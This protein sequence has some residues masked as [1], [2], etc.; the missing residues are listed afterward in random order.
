L[1]Y[2]PTCFGFPLIGPFVAAGLYDISRRRSKGL[3]ITWSDVL[4]VVIGQGR[5]ELGWMAFVVLFVFWIWMYQ[6]RLLFALFVGYRGFSTL[7]TFV[8]FLMTSQGL[9]FLFV[10][11][12]VG[13]VLATVLFSLTVIAMPMLLDHDVDFVTAISTSVRTVIENPRAM[14]TFGIAVAVLTFVAMVPMFLGLLVVLPILG[15]ATWHLY[16]RAHIGRVS[17]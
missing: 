10:G 7:D 15:H 1:A 9:T 14:F 2:P 8:S 4:S 6:I 11:T 5:R 17:I 12:L 13:A 16:Q 3:P